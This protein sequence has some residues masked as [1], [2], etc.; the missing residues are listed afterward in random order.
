[1]SV[2]VTLN[3]P[4]LRPIVEE[5]VIVNKPLIKNCNKEPETASLKIKS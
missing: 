2:I 4:C 3:R 5:T 1:M